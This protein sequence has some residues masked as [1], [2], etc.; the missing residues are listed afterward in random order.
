[1]GRAIS[2]MTIK[3]LLDYIKSIHNEH[4]TDSWMRWIGSIV[5]AVILAIVMHSWL[6]H[7]DLPANLSDFLKWQ[8]SLIFGAGTARK[9]FGETSTPPTQ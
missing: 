1:M 4:S 8:V 3:P 2:A 7:I 6:A 9:I 5:I